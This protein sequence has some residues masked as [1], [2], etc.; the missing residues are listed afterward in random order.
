MA[1]NPPPGKEMSPRVLQGTELATSVAAPTGVPWTAFQSA[2]FEF[3]AFSPLFSVWVLLFFLTPGI[4]FCA[5][6]YSRGNLHEAILLRQALCALL[7]DGCLRE[8]VIM[9]DFEPWV[10]DSLT[11]RGFTTF[12]T[13]LL[14]KKWSY[15]HS[16]PCRHTNSEVRVSESTHPCDGRFPERA[17]IPQGWASLPGLWAHGTSW[18]QLN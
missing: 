9:I 13:K 4:S 10:T 11:V 3:A 17:N 16:D 1:V 15:I 2:V 7:N 5:D 18:E 14:I 6:P 12:K 8:M